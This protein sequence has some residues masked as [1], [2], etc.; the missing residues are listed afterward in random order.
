[1]AQS[2]WSAYDGERNRKGQ[3]AQAERREAAM[4]R[5]RAARA[6]GRGKRQV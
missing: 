6:A 1:M 2:V 5:D 4:R 3:Q